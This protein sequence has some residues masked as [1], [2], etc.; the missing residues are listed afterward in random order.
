MIAIG[1]SAGLLGSAALTRFLATM[2]CEIVPT[3]PII[4]Q[5]RPPG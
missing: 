5:D 3:D 4:F 2:L 1:V